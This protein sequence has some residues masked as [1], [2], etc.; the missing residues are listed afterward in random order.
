MFLNFFSRKKKARTVNE[1]TVQEVAIFL[2]KYELKESLRL[3][4][5][6][7][8]YHSVVN[9]RLSVKIT[10]KKN[11]IYTIRK[12]KVFCSLA[13]NNHDWTLRVSKLKYPDFEKEKL[14]KTSVQAGA[15]LN[16]EQKSI[17]SF[18]TSVSDNYARN[19]EFGP[20][21]RLMNE[22]KFAVAQVYFS[23]PRYV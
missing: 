10:W 2:W 5:A 21:C 22:F 13:C 7:L 15:S 16:A 1:D 6:I 11:W 18:L 4:W 8:I 12:F 17:P 20:C 23:A 3:P 9:S 14:Q 19:K